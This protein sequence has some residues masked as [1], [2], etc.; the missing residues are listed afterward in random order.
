MWCNKL[1]ELVYP[2]IDRK[3]SSPS[4][5]KPSHHS[6][7]ERQLIPSSTIRPPSSIRR[8]SLSLIRG[9]S[10]I[11]TGK[12]HR[13]LN[14]ST[15]PLPEDM[16]SIRAISTN[17]I[18]HTN[19]KTTAAVRVQ[20]N[21]AT[22]TLRISSASLRTARVILEAGCVAIDIRPTMAVLTRVT[23]LVRAT[24]SSDLAPTSGDLALN[25]WQA[26]VRA[27]GESVRVR[28][29]VGR[30]VVSNLINSSVRSVPFLL[31]HSTVLPERFAVLAD[32][33]SVEA[34]A[35]CA[36]VGVGLGGTGGCAATAV[37]GFAVAPVLV[38]D[39]GALAI[40][41]VWSVD[42]AGVEVGGSFVAF[43][44]VDG[45]VDV[46]VDD[47]ATGRRSRRWLC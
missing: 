41:V 31:I 29:R 1:H 4:L 21:T 16:P 30:A 17:S 36:R 18:L 45:L 12:M 47:Y 39:V 10:A 6:T 23:L 37:E 28:H 24:P 34:A 19:A 3:Q 40:A 26:V 13:R 5:A 20:A 43:G 32:H 11:I 15:L 38:A 46:A 8:S 9:N 44:V 2:E 35:G 25:A 27:V 22:A 7:L 14:I 42:G 33:V